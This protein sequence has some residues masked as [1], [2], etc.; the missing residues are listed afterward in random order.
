MK[1]GES[2]NQM[3]IYQTAP[4][5]DT[6]RAERNLEF[7]TAAE[8]A[9][10]VSADVEWIVRPWIAKGA[11]TELD[12][13]VKSAGKTTWVTF[14][15]R[16]VL[17]GLRFLDEP[18]LQTPIVYLTEQPKA[19]FRELLARADL[20]ERE[21]FFVLFWNQKASRMTWPE[22]AHE[23]IKKAQEA[24]AQLL[25]VDTIAQFANLIGDREN[26]SGDAL[27]AVKPLQLAVENGLAVLVVR[28]EG[29]RGGAVGLGAVALPFPE[30]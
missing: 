16:A 23:A 14:M 13:K 29:K 25:V 22:I 9:T 2:K 19:S 17:D 10:E 26:N 12:G 28:H 7:M 8:I 27:Q 21:D 15:C 5:R 11:I 3:G 30:P 4:D 20:L 18:T 6:V 1:N 24:G